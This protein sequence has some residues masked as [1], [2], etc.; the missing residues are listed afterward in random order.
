MNGNETKPKPYRSFCCHACATVLTLSLAP[1]LAV[2]QVVYDNGGPNQAGGNEMTAWIQA[3]NFAFGTATSFQSVRFW[4]LDRY[5]G[6]SYQGSIVWQIYGNS[7]GQPGALLSSGTAS[8]VRTAT[9]AVGPYTEYQN[10]FSVGSISLGPGMYWLGLHNGPLSTS[11]AFEFYW[12]ATG[13]ANSPAGQQQGPPFGGSAW[14]STGQE[15]AFQLLSVPEPSA[16]ALL[17]LGLVSRILFRS[18]S[19]VRTN[20]L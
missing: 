5:P 11:S 13:Q 15:H 7:A 1:H 9:G 4:D 19:G 20:Y 14:G 8:P 3:E 2:G 18:R 6:L 12:E 10:D 17:C 16:W